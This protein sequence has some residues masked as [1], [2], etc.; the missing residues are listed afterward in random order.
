MALA[1]V[2]IAASALVQAMVTDGWEG[3]RNRVA[4][5][6]G[7]GRP[8][9]A[10]E[11][12]LDATRD[13]LRAAQ[14]GEVERLQAE[15]TSQWEVRL[16]DLLADHPDAAGELERLV[17]EIQTST[18]TASDHSLAAR[19]VRMQADRGGVNA[20]VIHGAVNTGPTRPGPASS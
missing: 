2:A 9:Q 15:L 16:A 7:R 8:D 6:F 20:G 3:V 19:N 14:P 11:R 17:A 18:A 13:Q 10:I 4:S 5:I 12:R 1:L